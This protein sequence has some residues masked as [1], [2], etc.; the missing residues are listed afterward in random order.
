M[1]LSLIGLPRKYAASTPKRFGMRSIRPAMNGTIASAIY[2]HVF[3]QLRIPLHA[4][5][6]RCG[7]TVT[8]LAYD[9]RGVP[10]RQLDSESRCSVLD[11]V[12]AQ[13]VVDRPEE[14]L[15]AC[16]ELPLVDRRNRL[17]RLIPITD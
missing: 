5:F 9:K 16:A 6:P 7:R 8:A 10:A 15:L 12:V 1:Y 11:D 4:R 17:A 13:P 14:R 3:A 2:K